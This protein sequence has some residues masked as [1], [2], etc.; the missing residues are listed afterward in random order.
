MMRHEI[1]SADGTRLVVHET[2]PQDA[3]AIVLIHGWSQCHLSWAQQLPLA[4]SFRLILPDLRG[5]GASGAPLDDGAYD[6]SAP[7]AA[8]IHAILTRLSLDKPLLVGWSMG[9]WI[10]LDYLRIFS[11][12]ALAGIVQIGTSVTTGRFT[13]PDALSYRENDPDV[14]AHGM[15]SEDLAENLNATLRFVKTCFATPPEGDTLAQMIGFNM[16]VSPQVRAA[17]RR[18]HED[19]RPTARATKVPALILWGRKERL[20]PDPIGEE[21]LATFPDARARIYETAGHAPFW[22]EPDC[23]NADLTEFAQHCFAK[24]REAIASQKAEAAA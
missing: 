23:F 22:D 7:W 17:A 4:Q 5:H 1:T 20:A 6:N 10:V 14:V 13:P 8:D 19:Y 15:Y 3:P 11:D 2:G 12:A 21:A 18:R 24:A 9:G 16:L